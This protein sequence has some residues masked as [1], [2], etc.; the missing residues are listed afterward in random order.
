MTRPR[1]MLSD[2]IVTFEKDLAPGVKVS[3]DGVPAK[4]RSGP[5][6]ERLFDRKTS[7][8]IEELLHVAREMMREGEHEIQ[9]RFEA[10]V[11]DAP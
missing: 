3:I 1:S 11:I 2:A 7:A 4:V 5:N 10:E 9:L 6:P 8:R